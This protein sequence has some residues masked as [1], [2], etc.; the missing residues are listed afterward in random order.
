MSQI[1]GR[2]GTN[3]RVSGTLFKM[4][5]QEVILLGSMTYMMNPCMGRSMGGYQ[6]RVARR[7]TGNQIHNLW[8]RIWYYPPL[9]ESVREAGLDKV[10]E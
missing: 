8:Y 5:D 9:E 1:L 10:E 2:E 7:L 6:H 3:V 4:V